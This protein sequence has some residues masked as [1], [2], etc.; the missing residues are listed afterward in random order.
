MSAKVQP[1][2]AT[3]ARIYW[4]PSVGQGLF[5]VS[6]F[7]GCLSHILMHTSAPQMDAEYHPTMSR[8][9]KA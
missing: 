7:R 8:C 3:A 9:V 6:R 1:S 2:G 5:G 4:I